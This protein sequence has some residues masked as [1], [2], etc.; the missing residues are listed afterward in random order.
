MKIN[1][2]NDWLGEP[3]E[4][5]MEKVL[6]KQNA[7][8]Q[9]KEEPRIIVPSSDIENPEN[10]LILER[11]TYEPL[12]VSMYRLGYN[13]DV[14]KA[15]KALGLNVAHRAEE[16]NGREYAG[17]LNWEQA[18]RLNLSLGNFTLNP[19][20]FADFL[21]MLKSGNGFDGKG[22]RVDGR[23]LNEIL[24]EIMGVRSPWRGEHLDASFKKMADKFTIDYGHR[25]ANGQLIAI[26]SEPL[27][28]HLREDCKVDL[29][30]FNKHGLP[31]KEGNDFDY[32]YPR[33]NQLPVNVARFGA[34]SGGADLV[35]DRDPTDTD[36]ALGVR[37]ARLKK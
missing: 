12:L 36:V 31:T 10:Y 4:G 27:E 32:W 15:A 7:K 18:L 35:C 5:S 28:E 33:C 22:N 9:P 2:P 19:R 14:E 1:I 13:D 26:N 37:P 17:R 25:L 6:A 3:I 20:E 21:L 11:K 8:E 24:D 30:S 29:S 34:D 16:N 23:K